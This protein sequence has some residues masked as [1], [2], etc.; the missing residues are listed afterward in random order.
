MNIFIAAITELSGKKQIKNVCLFG[1]D[2]YI[3]KP[4]REAL[5]TL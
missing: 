5:L 1:A 4:K 3:L 2:Y